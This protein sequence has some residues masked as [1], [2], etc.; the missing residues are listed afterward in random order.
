MK[1]Y[2]FGYIGAAMD[3]GVYLYFP[4]PLTL[5]T[6]LEAIKAAFPKA[7][8]REQVKHWKPNSDE[9]ISSCEKINK[10]SNIPLHGFVLEFLLAEG[11]EPFAGSDYGAA[12]PMQIR[13]E[14]VS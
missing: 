11:W 3:H 10:N 14:K 1:Q 12:P 4:D 2:E 9:I 5:A 6:L 7:S 8:V 13:R